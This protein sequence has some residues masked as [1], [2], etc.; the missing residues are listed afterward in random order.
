MTCH[1]L[2]ILTAS[3]SRVAA[4][5]QELSTS[6][7]INTNFLSFRISSEQT[8]ECPLSLSA[9][10]WQPGQCFPEH[11]Q[12]VSPAAELLSDRL[13]SLQCQS[14][15]WTRTRPI[16]CA[17]SITCS[18]SITV[19]ACARREFCLSKCMNDVSRPLFSYMHTK[20]LKHSSAVCPSAKA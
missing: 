12:P 20:L 4:S 1:A 7:N 8:A 10:S 11:S 19:R 13:A 6:P 5:Q 14:K 2:V 18:G 9:S 16:L 15:S 3:A 17:T